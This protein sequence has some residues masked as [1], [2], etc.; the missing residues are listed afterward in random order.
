MRLVAAALT[1]LLASG[2]VAATT[3]AAAMDAPEVQPVP[4]VGE[5]PSAPSTLIVEVDDE[6]DPTQLGAVLDVI[7]GDNID[8]LASSPRFGRMT[9]DATEAG[10]ALIRQLSVV[11][12]VTESRRL[13]L[14]LEESVAVVEGDLLRAAGA[15]GTGKVVAVIDSGVDT[16]HPGLSTSIVG[17]ACFL[18]GSSSLCPES[19][20]DTAFGTGAGIPCTGSPSECP[21]GSHVSGII[22]ANSLAIGTDVVDGV[23]PDVGI[24]A[25][26]VF[27]DDLEPYAPEA[28]VLDALGYVLS[29]HEG[30]MDIAAVNLSL[31]IQVP[32]CD[33]GDWAGP[34]AAL[35]AAGVAVVAASGNSPGNPVAFP[36][37]MDGV[38]SVGATSRDVPV[39]VSYDC[40]S[41]APVEIASF[42]QV[43]PKL[44]LVAPG[45]CIDS[46]VTTD[47]DPDGISSWNGTSMAA[48]HV[49]AL[50]ALLDGNQSGWSPERSMELLRA[51]GEMVTFVTPSPSDRD[52]RFPEPRALA[53]LGF[54]PFTDADYGFWVIAA[55]WA[56]ATGVSTGTGGTE[57][58]HA[59]TLSRAE[60]VTFLWRLMGSP[61]PTLAN[62][63]TDVPAG[64]WYSEA[65]VWAA[66]VHI[67]TGTTATT[68]EPDAGV[69]RGQVATF[70]W[71]L[72]GEPDYGT[73]S[74][75]MDVPVGQFYTAPV[76]W[77]ALLEITTGTS[78]TTFSPAE[79]V[80]RAQMITFLWR[81]VNTGDAWSPGIAVPDG[82]LF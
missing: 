17:E 38:V 4:T 40:S 20:T 46:T 10:E 18:T 81:L 19:G 3:G 70:F 74:G 61:A 36:A 65:V 24:L 43:G 50:L 16:S 60:A 51:T 22:T 78:A 5:E 57:F 34:V 68:F 49:T 9:V 56:K 21:H 47:Y 76:T 13:D 2:T 42:T 77:M 29:L 67:T 80:T 55:D 54:E 6:V 79:V 23:A 82:A 39:G 58:D 28:A 12:G 63:F 44:D 72:V 37:C 1:V 25:I 75:F 53:A 59:R 73:N 14:F 64:T 31:G 66:E 41:D 11:A 69:T 71:R 52:P 33:P 35:N 45:V 26:R 62:P 30:G 48:P 8:V 27:T 15:T 7:A 32:G